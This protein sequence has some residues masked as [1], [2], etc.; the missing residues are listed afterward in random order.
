[1]VTHMT[2]LKIDA[3]SVTQAEMT[4]FED[5]VSGLG[6]DSP[7]ASYMLGVVAELRQGMDL[8]TLESFAALSPADAAKHLKISRTFLMH[9]IKSGE[10][11]ARKKGSHHVITVHD[12]ADFRSRVLR[13][14]ETVASALGNSSATS[15]A[16]R[17]DARARARA[18][19]LARR[20]DA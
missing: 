16:A 9:Y 20:N 8:T 3:A 18:A 12:L 17:D 14:R 15:D 6:D 1:M 10:L 7:L 11:K 4:K 2:T 19:R 5:L 13:G